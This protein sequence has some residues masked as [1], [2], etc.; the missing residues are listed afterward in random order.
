MSAHEFNHASQF[1]YGSG[2]EFWYWEATATYM[3]E[4]VYPTHNAWVYYVN[5]Y[6]QQPWLQMSESNQAD[7]GLFL[8]MY[9]MSIWNF[10]IDENYGGLPTIQ[11]MWAWSQAHGGNYD[12]TQSDLL[13]G[14]GQDFPEIYK[15]FTAA[16][17][18][19]TYAEQSA[20]P[21][22]SLRRD[23]DEVPAHGSSDQTAPGSFGQ[24]YIRFN[25]PK[26]DADQPDLDFTFTGDAPANWLV[27]IVGTGTS[28]LKTTVEMTVDGTTG[29]QRLEN[30]GDYGQIF[31]VISP[32]KDSQGTFD[33]SWTADPVEALPGPIVTV[34]PPQ[35]PHLGAAGDAENPN[36]AGI[37]CGCATGSPSGLAGIGVVLGAIALRRRRSPR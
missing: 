16:N 28:E 37:G 25:L 13:T 9:G 22:V 34:P 19:M 36:G 6:S 1:S 31:L 17:T 33:Y 12:L 18:V 8:H 14:V 23:I 10:W 35:A 27:Q 4:Y 30:Y 2:I 20:Y 3:Q 15:G 26:P 32:R 29:E 7:Y 11:A 21:A 24:N 5:G